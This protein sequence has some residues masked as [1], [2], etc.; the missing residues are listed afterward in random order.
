MKPALF[1]GIQTYKHTGKTDV[2]K[3]KENKEFIGK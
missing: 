2:G 1:D 3:N